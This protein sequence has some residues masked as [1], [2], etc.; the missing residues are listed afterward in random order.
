MSSFEARP[1]KLFIGGEWV[2]AASG[3][4]YTIFN[5]ATES[6][7]VEVAAAGTED[8][9]RAVRAARK[10]FDSDAWKNMRSRD[11]GRLLWKIADKL[12]ENIEEMSWL[13]TIH[14]GKPIIESK[15]ADMGSV[16]DTFQYYAG[17][18]T[19]LGGDTIPVGPNSLN[20]TLREPLGVIGAIVAWNFPLM[21]AAWKI[22]PALATGN[23]VVIKPAPNTPLS[24]LRFAELAQSCGLPPGVLNVVTG[25]GP[26][27]GEALVDHPDV[28]KIAFTGSTAVGKRIMGR[29]AQTL[30]KVSLELG[31]KSPNVVF[32]DADIEAALKGATAGIFYGK[33]EVCA[34]GSR[35][36]VQS[37]I[38]DEF[39][40]KLAARAKK[41]VCMDPL[42]P[43]SRLGAIAS[44]AQL[45]KVV[46]YV[47]LGT[48]E[49]A[50]L[51]AGGKRTDI[52]TGRGYFHEATV[53]ANVKND[54][55][56][57][58]EEIFGPVLSVIRFEDL[59]DAVR[60]ANDSPYGLAAAV[61]TQ[62]VKK[63]HRVARA[64]KAGTVW[65]NAYNN[66]DASVPFGGY[67]QSGFGREKGEAALEGYTQVKAV[68]VDLGA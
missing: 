4:T 7:I 19:K 1:G 66:Y 58:R 16:I 64:L 50:S 67:K 8:V 40:E 60:Q 44:L 55:R 35:L 32:A 24:L 23:T 47:Q 26:D 52:G 2:E 13:E 53:F 18:T 25:P 34:A 11:R 54:M 30:K 48:E 9:D 37:S 12:Q 20:Y 46:S 21:L 41:T 57:A 49:G 22:A 59:D 17:W 56:L 6:P 38:Y 29:A 62:D 68:W 45:E 15:L 3:Q 36:L 42:D 5:P 65:V 14:N 28:D 61:W 63:A 27:V 33:G 51:V 31:G 10:A 39:V 43:K